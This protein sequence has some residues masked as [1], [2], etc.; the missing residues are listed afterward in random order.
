MMEEFV[1]ASQTLLDL[2]L[3]Q[4]QVDAFEHY[5]T[6][7]TKWNEQQNLTAIIDPQ[8][9]LIRH[10]LDSLTCLK[11][12]GSPA[13]ADQTIN[14]IDVGSGAGFPG[15]PLKI[16]RPE[17]QLTLLEATEKKCKFLRHM[18]RE[19]KLEEVHVIQGRAEDVARQSEHRAVYD[20]AVARALARMPVLL[21]LLLPFVRSAGCCLAQ[22]GA[23]AHAE[24]QEVANAL[25]I[26]GGQIRQLA[27]IELP[28][29]VETRYLVV[30]KKVSAT[31]DKYPRRAG[32]PNKRPL[33]NAE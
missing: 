10:F 20:W 2:Y 15:L 11:L 17:L 4:Q 32:I 7:L 24:S 21:E 13:Q 6:E 26:L 33:L 5:A 27:P 8:G 3:S 23:N 30:V 18:V 25:A 1:A 22:R 16:A 19:L 9:I 14:I 12:I 31:P 28:G 29:V